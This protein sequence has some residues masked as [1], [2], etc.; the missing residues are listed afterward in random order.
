MFNFAEHVQRLEQ[1]VLETLT[2]EMIAEW[3]EKYTYLGG[4]LYSFKDHEYQ[5]RIL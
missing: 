2:P 1:S 3:I 5:L 4:E